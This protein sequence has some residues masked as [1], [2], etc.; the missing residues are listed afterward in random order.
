MSFPRDPEGEH[1]Q[2]EP[3]GNRRRD[4][5][6]VVSGVVLALGIWFA[7]ANTEDVKI[8]FWVV[9][10]RTPVVSALG[11]AAVLGVALGLLL[12]RRFRRPQS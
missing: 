11:I 7:L 8:K 5:R 2:P 12:G 6:L 3:S 4:I 9:T 10:T 1:S